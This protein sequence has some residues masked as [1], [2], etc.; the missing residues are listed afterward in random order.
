MRLYKITRWQRFCAWLYPHVGLRPRW[1]SLYLAEQSYH[2][3]EVTRINEDILAGRL[4][5]QVPA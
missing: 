3:W 1:L 5:P 2:V 4:E